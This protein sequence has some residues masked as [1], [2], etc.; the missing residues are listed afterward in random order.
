M[1]NNGSFDINRLSIIPTEGGEFSTSSSNPNLNEPCE[2][3]FVHNTIKHYEKQIQLLKKQNFNLNL[4]LFNLR[5]LTSKRKWNDHS[6]REPSLNNEDVNE[7]V[8]S[9]KEYNILLDK[10]TKIELENDKLTSDIKN[11]GQI[12]E[13]LYFQI[14]ELNANNNSNVQDLNTGSKNDQTGINKKDENINDYINYSIMS[15][16][17]DIALNF[18]DTMSNMSLK[19]NVNTPKI[20]IN[21][22][23]I[24]LLSK[25]INQKMSSKMCK[26]SV[27]ND[28]L[29]LSKIY[30][31][32]DLSLNMASYKTP[33]SLNSDH[34]KRESINFLTPYLIQT[35]SLYRRIKECIPNFKN[36]ETMYQRRLT[37]FSNPNFNEFVSTPI[38][39]MNKINSYQ[40]K[41]NSE[42]VNNIS[43]I[44]SFNDSYLASFYDLPL[45]EQNASIINKT[46]QVLFNVDQ[47][48]YNTVIDQIKQLINN[49]D[50]NNR[51]MVRSKVA[52]LILNMTSTEFSLNE[53][54]LPSNSLDS[55]LKVPQNLST[56]AEQVNETNLEHHLSLSD[57]N[58]DSVENDSDMDISNQS[59]SIASIAAQDVVGHVKLD[60]ERVKQQLTETTTKNVLLTQNCNILFNLVKKAHKILQKSH[61]NS[62][63]FVDIYAKTQKF[64]NS[65]PKIEHT[66][67]NIKSCIASIEK[68]QNNH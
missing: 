62:Q 36:A 5:N 63:N 2:K 60:Y 35:N 46:F 21:N 17:V 6:N 43:K 9:I 50:E 54:Q 34:V 58:C 22:S 45:D 18:F 8:I 37:L 66:D 23:K 67:S 65:C 38:I 44:S 64:V 42:N 13:D 3:N 48:D 29:L 26:S 39:G 31:S 15:L 1:D 59:L 30:K 4:E 33:K 40:R 51:E 41:V 28:D 14:A 7:T 56:I 25:W 61:S 52:Q 19:K 12:M 32:T 47:N 16:F 10:Y 55:T 53:T 68:F 57:L 11:K 20:E 24:E 49:V 27:D